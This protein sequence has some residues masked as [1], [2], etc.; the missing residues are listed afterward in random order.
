MSL[1]LTALTGKAPVLGQDKEFVPAAE[2]I[3]ARAE[4]T[5]TKGE[6]VKGLVAL[7]NA[8]GVSV[9]EVCEFLK[10]PFEPL[11]ELTKEDGFPE[12][13]MRLSVLLQQPLEERLASASSIASA[14][15]LRIIAD[16]SSTNKDVIAAAKD[17]LDRHMGKAM[18]KVSIQSTNLSVDASF[19]EIQKNI[20]ASDARIS[21]LVEMRSK[22]KLGLAAP[23]EV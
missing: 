9:D 3:T 16:P 10:V 20:A 15:M 1:L 7:L 19:E 2:K 23:I 21:Q 18:Q 5:L 14:R 6:L 8:K 12:Q 17:V 4:N 13:V 11:N 22:L